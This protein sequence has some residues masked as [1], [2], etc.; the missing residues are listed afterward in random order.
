MPFVG[1]GTELMVAAS[2]AATTATILVAGA[3]GFSV[4]GYEAEEVDVTSMSSPGRR[5]ETIQG[6][7]KEIDISFEVFWNPGDAVDDLFM[8]MAEEK[9]DRLMVMTFDQVTPN[10]TCT[11]RAKL[12]SYKPE[13]PVAD[14]ATAQVTLRVTDVP[15]WADAA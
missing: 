9:T 5:R 2:H 1:I 15:V 12:F 4:P 6:I 13:A 8:E 3:K 7:A 10:R 14:A 11:F